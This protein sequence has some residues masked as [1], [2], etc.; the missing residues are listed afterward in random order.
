M[1]SVFIRVLQRNRIYWYIRGDLLWELAH[2]ILEVEISDYMGFASWRSRKVGGIIQSKSKGMKVRSS[3]VQGQKNGCCIL[4]EWELPL[5]CL[6]VLFGPSMDWMM[7]PSTTTLVRQ[8]FLIHST[9]LNVYFF[10]RLLH[11]HTQK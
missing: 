11:R 1:T 4:R 8:I 10:M 9:D 3:D 5:L 7:S 6:L 2:V